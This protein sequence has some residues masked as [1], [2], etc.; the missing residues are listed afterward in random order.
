MDT[1]TH[2]ALLPATVN[3][4]RT[5]TKVLLLVTFRP[6]QTARR[7][8]TAETMATSFKVRGTQLMI[9]RSL[10]TAPR[11]MFCFSPPLASSK[12][13]TITG[14][15]GQPTKLTPHSSE[16][17]NPKFGNTF[18]EDLLRPV[19]GKTRTAQLYD[20]LQYSKRK[21]NNGGN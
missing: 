20:R 18:N 12:W 17:R 9:S 14:Q 5:F 16:G 8:H 7:S 11:R 1:C 6:P 4:T 3:G 2:G 19:K 10:V 13:A 21:N 15:S